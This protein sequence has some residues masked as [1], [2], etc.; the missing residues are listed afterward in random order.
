MVTSGHV[1]PKA[2][3]QGI[4]GVGLGPTAVRGD[5]GNHGD[6]RT[7]LGKFGEGV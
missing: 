6:R 2:T 4:R 5:G 3:N 1:T 7:K